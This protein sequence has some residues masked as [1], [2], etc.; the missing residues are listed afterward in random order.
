MRIL[1]TGATGNVGRLVV[2]QLLAAGATQVRALTTDPARAAL[3]P[4]VEVVEGYLGR[5]ETLPRALAGVDRMYLAPLTKTVREVTA[6]A[7]EA[8][9]TRIVDLA[10]PE[11]SWWYDIEKAVEQSGIPW[12]HLEAGEFMTNTTVWAEQIRDRGEVREAYPRAANAPIAL[13]D[14]AAV[15]AKALLED[16]HEHVA[17][18]LTGPETLTRA[19]LVAQIGQALGREIPLVEVSHAEALAELSAV[20]GADSAAWYLDGC[21]ELARDPQPASPTVSRV[22]GRPGMRFAEWAVAHAELFR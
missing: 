14:I 17:Y 11:G 12:T 9:V 4:A 7:R 2:D 21:A 15:A 6:L 1:V 8:G 16:G 20:M 18:G 19:E 22:L 3:P 5:V 13:E 10:G